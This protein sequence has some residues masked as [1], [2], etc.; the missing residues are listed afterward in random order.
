MI[1]DCSIVRDV[2]ERALPAVQTRRAFTQADQDEYDTRQL[3]TRPLVGTHI[4]V[5]RV[6]V[7]AVEGRSKAVTFANALRSVDY[8]V[9]FAALSAL[10]VDLWA[11]NK[12]TGG[13]TLNLSVPAD[14]TIEY[15]AHEVT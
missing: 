13:F 2:S 3:L 9:M 10:S 7:A 4:A 12:T 8:A 6:T 1:V 11:S 5:G 15:I 14:A